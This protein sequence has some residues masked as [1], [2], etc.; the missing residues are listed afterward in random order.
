MRCKRQIRGRGNQR[1][2]SH[3]GRGISHRRVPMDHSYFATFWR[4][5]S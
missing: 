1:I 4:T 3:L 2:L 5:S